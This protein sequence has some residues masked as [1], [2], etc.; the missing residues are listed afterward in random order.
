MKIKI[1]VFK[2]DLTKLVNLDFDILHTLNF[3]LI[4]KKWEYYRPQYENR[5]VVPYHPTLLPLWETHFN[6]LCITCFYWS[7]YLLKYAMKC[8]PRGKLNLNTKNVE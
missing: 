5:I 6:I 7:C 2:D 3:F 8:E 1:V 4:L